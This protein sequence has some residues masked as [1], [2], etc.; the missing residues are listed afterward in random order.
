[1]G[2]ESFFPIFPLW[3]IQKI[4]PQPLWT[5]FSYGPKALAALSTFFP[6]TDYYYDNE[7]YPL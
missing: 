6:P 3:I 1:M 7:S 5:D 4:F 2:V